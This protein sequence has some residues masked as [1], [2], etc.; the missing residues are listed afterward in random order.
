MTTFLIAWF[1][2]GAHLGPIGPRWA[3]CRPNDLCY[4]GRCPDDVGK[5]Q[6]Y[7]TGKAI[8]GHP[9]EVAIW[10]KESLHID[11][12]AQD[13]NDSSALTREISYPC[14]KPSIL[15]GTKFMIVKCLCDKCRHWITSKFVV[16]VQLLSKNICVV[17]SVITIMKCMWCDGYMPSVRMPATLNS[18]L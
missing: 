7:V 3:P 4:L 10:G 12:P 2:C 6:N 9:K 11:F 15:Y 13:C 17:F 5:F 14:A 16:E 18:Q 8:F 1:I